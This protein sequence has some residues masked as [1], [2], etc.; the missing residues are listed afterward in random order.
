MLRRGRTWH[1]RRRIPLRLHGRL[2][3]QV[4]TRSLRFPIWFSKYVL[5]SFDRHE[6]H[7]MYVQ[8]PA[9][10]LH[11]IEWTTRNEVGWW[12]WLVQSRR[13]SGETLFFQDRSR[14]GFEL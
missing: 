11:R 6:L 10:D 13:L 12:T 5:F 9:C 2:G 1:Y 3:R 14:T 7:H 8:V 4:F